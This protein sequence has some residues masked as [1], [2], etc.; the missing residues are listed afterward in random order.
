MQQDHI[1]IDVETT[2]L[3]P[4]TN[5]IIEIAAIRT[6]SQGKITDSYTDRII[7]STEVSESAAKVNGYDAEKWT[8]AVP[9]ATAMHALSKA[10]VENKGERVVMVAHFADFDRSFIK[11]N[12]ERASTT[13]PL[14]E[15]AWIDTGALLWPLAFNGA[16]KSRALESA[17][18]YFDII[19]TSPH[20]APGDCLATCKLYWTLMRRYS[21]A[22]AV[23]TAAHSKWG[24]I[25]TGIE[26]MVTGFDG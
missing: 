2:G 18:A 12:C 21:V 16:I 22:L 23:S 20:T 17:C 26:R 25:V 1:F 13:N 4:K 15:R 3:D 14:P 8:D 11:A 19:N 7:P 5:S 24:G 6:D 10:I 9:F